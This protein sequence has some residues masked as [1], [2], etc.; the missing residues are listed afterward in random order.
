MLLEDPDAIDLETLG[1]GPEKRL[2]V[3]AGASTPEELVEKLLTR[4]AGLFSL[5][6]KT[7]ELMKEDVVFKAPVIK[8][9]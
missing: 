5:G 6:V 4:L 8:A 2:G 3:T 9:H 1:L 7:L